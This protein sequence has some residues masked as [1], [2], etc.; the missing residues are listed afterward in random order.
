MK[1]LI[2]ELTARVD[3]LENNFV[4]LNADMQEQYRG[5]YIEMLLDNVVNER[6]EDKIKWST[7]GFV[8]M[9]TN[10]ANENIMQFFFN[11]LSDLTVIDVDTLRMY[12]ASAEIDWQDIQQKYGID[13]DRLKLVKE[14]LVRLGLLYRRNDQLRDDNLDA[15][16]DYLK[17]RDADSKKKKPQGVRLPNTI[18]KIGN[19]ETYRIST[20]GYGFLKSIGEA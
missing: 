15:I 14:K 5:T 3:S 10:E 20:L 16:V 19:N 6:Q 13:S 4:N 8:N 9:M 7:N 11:T 17:K 2:N 12:S 1:R 18:K